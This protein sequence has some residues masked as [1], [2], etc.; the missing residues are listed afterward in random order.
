MKQFE[1][2]AEIRKL[3]QADLIQILQNFTLDEKK[4]LKAYLE[5]KNAND[6]NGGGQFLHV[7]NF[8]ITKQFPSK[9]KT[10]KPKFIDELAKVLSEV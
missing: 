9:P 5:E 6:T 2:I 4:E 3:K 1:N 7:K 8:I 10:S